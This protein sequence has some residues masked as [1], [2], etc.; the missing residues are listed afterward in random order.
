MKRF[1]FLLMLACGGC[2]STGVTHPP[3][4]DLGSIRSVY[5]VLQDEPGSSKYYQYPRNELDKMMEDDLAARG[6]KISAGDENGAPAGVQAVVSYDYNWN[7]DM[8]RY[9]EYFRIEFRDPM[10]RAVIAEAE[11]RRMTWARQD[12]ADE[13]RDT[14][15]HLIPAR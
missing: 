4:R 14:L 2:S 11:S 9:L 15:D 7:W 12:A 5:L 6:F 1:M 8:S 3:D 13:V 10:S